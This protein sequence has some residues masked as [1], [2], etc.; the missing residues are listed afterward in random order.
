VCFEKKAR[1]STIRDSRRCTQRFKRFPE[2]K[3]GSCWRSN[4]LYEICLDT[5]APKT[6]FTEKNYGPSWRCSKDGLALFHFK[7]VSL[8]F[9]CFHFL[10]HILYQKS[11]ISIKEIEK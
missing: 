5:L 9:I 7:K 6:W 10:G 4:G 3:R 8:W 11:I 1:R 2:K